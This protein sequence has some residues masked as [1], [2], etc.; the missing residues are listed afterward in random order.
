MSVIIARITSVLPRTDPGLGTLLLIVWAWGAARPAGL[1]SLAG[2][3]GLPP[4]DWQVAVVSAHKTV[5][6]R[7][8]RWAGGGRSPSPDL[9]CHSPCCVAIISPT[10]P[11][12]LGPL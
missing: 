3:P 2:H 6:W 5:R 10:A 4:R 12:W 8:S 9:C 1:P 11:P 7:D